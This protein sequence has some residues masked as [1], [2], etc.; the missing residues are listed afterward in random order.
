MGSIER[1]IEKERPAFAAAREPKRLPLEEISRIRSF[2]L[3]GPRVSA[4]HARHAI[5]LV[6]VVIDPVVPMSVE[7]GEAALQR[8]VALRLAHVPLAHHATGV[9][10]AR[11]HIADRLLAW[12]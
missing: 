1:Q 9:A 3:L 11:E 6:R 2:I 10:G 4:E 8:K 12:V 7:E 5:A